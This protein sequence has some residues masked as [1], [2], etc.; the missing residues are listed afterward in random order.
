MASDGQL[1][2]RA[3]LRAYRGEGVQ[4]VVGVQSVNVRFSVI[5]AHCAIERL[6]DSATALLLCIFIGA[7]QAMEST[8]GFK[9]RN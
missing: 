1:S 2:H 6:C 4:R 7:E 8:H 3:M 9:T 5:L